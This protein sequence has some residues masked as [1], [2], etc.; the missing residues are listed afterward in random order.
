MYKPRLLGPKL[1]DAAVVDVS[2]QAIRWST[3]GGARGAF[4][5]ATCPS[6]RGLPDIRRIPFAKERLPGT[7]LYCL[8]DRLRLQSHFLEVGT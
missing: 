4:A 1:V 5:V 2:E 8:A 3:A 7:E 6:G